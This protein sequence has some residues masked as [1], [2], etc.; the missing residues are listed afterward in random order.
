MKMDYKRMPF[1]IISRNT[2]GVKVVQNGYYTY[3]SL[4]TLAIRQCY[5][6]DICNLSELRGKEC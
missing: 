4:I 5:V 1:N 2:S 3:L 6:K